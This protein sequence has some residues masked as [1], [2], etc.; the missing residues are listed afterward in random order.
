MEVMSST[1]LPRLVLYTNEMD[2]H[3]FVEVVILKYDH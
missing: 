1:G 2:I 3:D